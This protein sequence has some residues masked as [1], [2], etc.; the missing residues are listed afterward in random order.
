MIRLKTT[1]RPEILLAALDEFGAAMKY[2]HERKD[3]QSGGMVRLQDEDSKVVVSVYRTGTVTVQGEGSSLSREVLWYL[4]EKLCEAPPTGPPRI[5]T[6]ESGKG[7]Y[8]GHLVVAGVFVDASRESVLRRAGVVDCKR[9]SD[10]AVFKIASEITKTCPAKW[11]TI[12]PPRYNELY[13]R[14]RNVNAI[15]AWAHG[16]VIKDL[17]QI[18]SA[19]VVVTDKFA[20]EARLRKALSSATGLPPVVQRPRAEDDLAV[21]AASVVARAMFLRSIEALSKKYEVE[22]P[23]GA[24]DVENVAVE[25]VRSRG[26]DVLREVAKTHFKTTQRVLQKA[27]QTSATD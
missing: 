19:E 3:T 10:K 1:K 14:L 4:E 13:E 15:L 9:L 26:P 5:G 20:P 7:D 22:F 8:F 11:V 25:L 6:D 21:A 24:S 16:R 23:R 2:R 12:G 17:A 18:V 27:A